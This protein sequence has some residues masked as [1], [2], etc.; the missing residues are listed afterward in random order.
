M[1]Y[2]YC[3]LMDYQEFYTIH[4]TAKQLRIH[5]QTLYKLIWA[6]Q[7]PFTKIGGQ[8]RITATQIDHYLTSKTR[9]ATN[10]DF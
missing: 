1:N 5:P 10:G 8:Y 7:F 2:A 3:Y 4:E 6:K 9:K